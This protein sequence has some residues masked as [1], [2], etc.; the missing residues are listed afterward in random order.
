MAK[1]AGNET[2]GRKVDLDDL[3]PVFV[4]SLYELL[5]AAE[6]QKGAPLTEAEALGVRDAATVVM[7]PRRRAEEL[8]QARSPS[9]PEV[10]PD[11]VWADWQRHRPHP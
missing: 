11:R 10:D 5:A 6:V 4:P 3:V 8:R 2:S 1:G 7:M 9:V